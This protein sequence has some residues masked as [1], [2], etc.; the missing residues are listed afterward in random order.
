MN[1]PGSVPR[2]RR[3]R[4]PL[5][6]AGLALLALAV[7]FVL[8]IALGKALND[9]PQSGGTVTYVRT[10]KPLPQQPASP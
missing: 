3:K 9:S 4:R 8:G 7:V 5:L 2:P 6:R 1:R 10:L